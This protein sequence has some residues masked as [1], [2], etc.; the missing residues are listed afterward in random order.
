M[1]SSV[2]SYRDRRVYRTRILLNIAVV[3]ICCIGLV[4][5]WPTTTDDSPRIR[6][7]DRREPVDLT[8][9]EQTVQR[10]Q[11]PPPP[12]PD[13]QAPPVEV[14]DDVMLPDERLDLSLTSDRPPGDADALTQTAGTDSV[15]ADG[16][17]A[18]EQPPKPVRLVEPN[19]TREAREE[20][21]RA[22]IVIEVLVNDSGY[23]A[24][25]QIVQRHLLDEFGRQLRAVDRI[26][27]GLEEAA[28]SAAEK[29]R[30]RPGRRDG[31]PVSAYTQ[32][33]FSFGF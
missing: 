30:F 10:R 11:Q 12:P 8:V 13:V 5:W 23:V 27:Y 32:V 17:V 15:Q 2:S 25:Q 29:W 26:G 19:Y 33:T 21:I 3:L 1:E 24:E 7:I 9:V 16:K 22:R 4:R 20:G 18:L 14:P 31:T 6:A 28:L